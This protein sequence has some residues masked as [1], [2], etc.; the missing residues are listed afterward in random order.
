M[1][2]VWRREKNDPT[3]QPCALGPLWPL[4]IDPELAVEAI[5]EVPRVPRAHLEVEF[6]SNYRTFSPTPC[7]HST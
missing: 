2:Y 3:S 7:R 4:N 5:R 1:W 6:S